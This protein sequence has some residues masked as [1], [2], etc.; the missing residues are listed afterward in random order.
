MIDDENIAIDALSITLINPS[1]ITVATETMLTQG[2]RESV[3]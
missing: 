2:S 1:G 3:L